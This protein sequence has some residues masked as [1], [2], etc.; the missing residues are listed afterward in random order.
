MIFY[1]VPPCA[2]IANYS[3]RIIVN[4]TDNVEI[5]CTVESYPQLE[6]DIEWYSLQNGTFLLQNSSKYLI[7]YSGTESND[8]DLVFTAQSQILITDVNLNDD[9]VYI[10]S[11]GPESTCNATFSI[12]VQGKSSNKISLKI[13]P[14]SAPASISSV[15]N[16]SIVYGIVSDNITLKFVLTDSGVPPLLPNDTQWIFN[17]IELLEEETNIIFSDDRLSL[18]LSNL[19]FANEGNYTIIITNPAGTDSATLFLDVEGEKVL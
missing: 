15:D 17:G 18:T 11:G 6:N 5:Q 14:F 10:C 9:G 3:T 1:T 13:F 7:D 12:I 2:T 8:T 4:V 19:T 16:T